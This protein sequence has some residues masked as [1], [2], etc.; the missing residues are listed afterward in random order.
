MLQSYQSQQL[1]PILEDLQQQ[2]A[3]GT[4]YLEAEINSIH[5]KISRVLILKDGQI[6]YGGLKIPKSQDFAKMLGQKFKREWID[7]AITFA[8]QKATTQTSVRELLELMVR[9]RMFTWEQIETLVHTQVV[10]TLEQVLPH[11]GQFQFDSRTQFDLCHGEVCYGLNLSRLMLDIT[12][13]QEQWSEFVSLI[14]SMEAIPRLQAHALQK[15]EDPSVRHP[16]F[17]QTDY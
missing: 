11:P 16:H 10:L 15:I 14:P 8:T 4:L 2:H 3:N 6:T 7:T 12:R 1:I 9:M 17:S 13:R 5:K